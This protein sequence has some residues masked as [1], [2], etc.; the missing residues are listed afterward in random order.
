MIAIILFLIGLPALFVFFDFLAFTLTGQ[1][2]LGKNILKGVEV[3]SLIIIT[4]KPQPLE[5]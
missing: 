4:G 1:Q 3:M 2:V 5:F